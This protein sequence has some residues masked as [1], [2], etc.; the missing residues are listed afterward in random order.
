MA[1]GHQQLAHLCNASTT[2][3]TTVRRH[4]ARR[5]RHPGGGDGSRHHP[6]AAG[7]LVGLLGRLPVDDL[8][9]IVPRTV[10]LLDDAQRLQVLRIL[11]GRS[12]SLG[13]A[14]L[15]L[16]MRSPSSHALSIMVNACWRTGNAHAALHH[17]LELVAVHGCRPTRNV[18]TTMIRAAGLC[19][20]PDMID[21]LW[22]LRRSYGIRADARMHA[23]RLRALTD[24]LPHDLLAPVIDQCKAEMDADDVTSDLHVY[25]ALIAAVARLPVSSS[26]IDVMFA[27]LLCSGLTPGIQLYNV[28]LDAFARQ[29]QVDRVMAVVERMR[30]SELT[31]TVFTYSITSHCLARNGAVHECRRVLDA[32]VH[33]GVRPNGV[34]LSGIVSGLSQAGLHRYR[35]SLVCHVYDLWECTQGPSSASEWDPLARSILVRALLHGPGQPRRIDDAH[36]LVRQSYAVT[37]RPPAIYE[38]RALATSSDLGPFLVARFGPDSYLYRAALRHA[39]RNDRLDVCDR[40]V[41]IVS[42]QRATLDNRTLRILLVYLINRLCT[43]PYSPA[44]HDHVQ[45]LYALGV[46]PRALTAS[47]SLLVGAV[48]SD[49]PGALLRVLSCRDDSDGCLA[50]A[51]RHGYLRGSPVFVDLFGRTGRLAEIDVLLGDAN[52]QARVPSANWYRLARRLAYDGHLGRAVLAMRYGRVGRG[53]VPMDALD[54]VLTVLGRAALSRQCETWLRLA[55]SADLSSYNRLMFAYRY[56]E[57]GVTQV[58]AR[59]RIQGLYEDTCTMNI[60]LGM[61]T[62]ADDATRL[63]DDMT[64]RLIPPDTRTYTQLLNALHRDFQLPHRQRSTI[65]HFIV[66]EIDRSGMVVSSDAFLCE[67]LIRALGPAGYDLVLR[68]YWPSCLSHPVSDIVWARLLRVDP[69]RTSTLVRR[70]MDAGLPLTSAIFNELIFRCRMRSDLPMIDRLLQRMDGAGVAYTLHTY[71][72]AIAAFGREHQVA[73]AVQL[74]RR[75]ID[76]GHAPSAHVVTALMGALGRDHRADQAHR[77]FLLT[78]PTLHA[79]AQP[80]LYAAVMLSHATVG[81]LAACRDLLDDARRDGIVPDIHMMNALIRACRMAGG[82]AALAQSIFD[83]IMDLGLAPTTTTYND[84]LHLYANQGDAER[85]QV[86]LDHMRQHQA[87]LQPD[88]RTFLLCAHAY[89]VQV[90]AQGRPMTPDISDR[91]SQLRRLARAA[92]RPCR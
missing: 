76:S 42:R 27:E 33:N 40:I 16:A 6:Q 60:M 38:V 24:A 19:R 31:P 10:G 4:V 35:Y 85:C 84:M 83:L 11:V 15:R 41:T 72:M 87:H 7:G 63:Y 12:V 92:P 23:G 3:C 77:L 74:W 50:L 37:Q 78:K 55:P 52:N 66:S 18:L 8:P 47:V 81:D 14:Y 17:A 21:A 45:W 82:Q 79:R 86:L 57:D 46:V 54:A 29:N 75:L 34:T 26:R 20:R 69:R 89:T 51:D 9:R 58:R 73:R 49:E 56:D 39:I 90:S 1:P 53:P 61:A 36:A 59:L 65:A 71:A 48:T 64:G 30:Q 2:T 28:L 70:F 5:L 13:Q 62:S 88:A 67:A 22:D 32:M 44:L 80:S 43:Y 25:G 68:R 91:I